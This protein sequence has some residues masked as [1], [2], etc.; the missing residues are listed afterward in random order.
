MIM[1]TKPHPKPLPKSRVSLSFSIPLEN[2]D[3]C[4]VLN[5]S[6]LIGE[7]LR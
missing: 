7:G 4:E 3:G 2:V 6:K 1:W 5:L